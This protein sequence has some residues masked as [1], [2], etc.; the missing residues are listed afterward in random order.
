MIRGEKERWGEDVE[1]TDFEDD[2]ND[3][4]NSDYGCGDEFNVSFSP[5]LHM[6]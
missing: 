5:D 4:D 1:R 2:D 3:D 6:F